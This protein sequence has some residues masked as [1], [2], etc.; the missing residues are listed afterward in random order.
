MPFP[1]PGDLLNPGIKPGS[2]A[3]QADSLPSEPPGKP[4]LW[5]GD[6][7]GPD[8]SPPLPG[9]PGQCSPRWSSQGCY[10]A[11]PT[12]PFKDKKTEGL[13]GRETYLHF[14]CQQRTRLGFECRLCVTPGPQM[15]ILIILILGMTSAARFKKS[16]GESGLL[17]WHQ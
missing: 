10:F 5:L 12:P 11:H 1:S 8:C 17:R 6:S 3:L 16:H 7:K 15:T 13:R 2:P 14:Q 4:T 9:V